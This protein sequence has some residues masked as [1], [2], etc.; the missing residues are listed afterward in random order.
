MPRDKDSGQ[1]IKDNN[2]E[3]H[4]C[5]GLFHYIIKCFHTHVCLRRSPHTHKKT[6]KFCGLD[7]LSRSLRLREVNLFKLLP[8]NFAIKIII[9]SWHCALSPS[10]WCPWPGS[11][12]FSFA[13]NTRAWIRRCPRFWFLC[14]LAMSLWEHYFLRKTCSK[15]WHCQQLWTW[16]FMEKRNKIKP[17]GAQGR[18]AETYLLKL[19][20][21][22]FCLCIAAEDQTNKNNKRAQKLLFALPILKKEQTLY[23]VWLSILINGHLCYFYIIHF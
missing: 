20:I 10:G 2:S 3:S 11:I 22:S 4:I 17:G 15:R 8:P 12:I 18:I 23:C 13:W 16:D 9:L 6:H 5:L 7:Y 14:F 19:P 1:R 21:F